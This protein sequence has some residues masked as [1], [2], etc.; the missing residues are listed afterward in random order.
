MCEQELDK[1]RRSVQDAV[2]QGM[3]G[4]NLY[5]LLL[6]G[7]WLEGCQLVGLLVTSIKQQATGS[8]GDSPFSLA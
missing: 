2:W 4:S 1:L 3:C 6:A 5:N 8:K 7:L